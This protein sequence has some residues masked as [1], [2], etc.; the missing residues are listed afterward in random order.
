MKSRRTKYGCD[1]GKRRRWT[2]LARLRQ[3]G[4]DEEIVYQSAS[5]SC[6][7]LTSPH[8]NNNNQTTPCQKIELPKVFYYYFILS[9]SSSVSSLTAC[10]CPDGCF[11]VVVFFS[12][13]ALRHDF[14]FTFRNFKLKINIQ[15]KCGALPSG[16]RRD[17][18]HFCIASPSFVRSS[19][20]VGLFI[21]RRRKT[22]NL[23]IGIF[24]VFIIQFI[25]VY[26]PRPPSILLHAFTS[27]EKYRIE[28]HKKC[29]SSPT[30]L[31]FFCPDQFHDTN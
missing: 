17:R 25:K 8:N 22:M 13:F 12:V 29:P 26:L 6:R 3:P 28:S 9:Y 19:P 2:M 1:V 24:S 21:R 31:Q 16:H 11:N 7:H 14:S 23:N 5:C 27:I 10:S 20:S 15:G 30:T 18:W 4:D